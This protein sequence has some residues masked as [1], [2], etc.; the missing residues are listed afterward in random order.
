MVAAYSRVFILVDALDES[1]VSDGCRQR[2]LSSLLNLQVECGINFFATSWPILRIEKEF[3]GVIMLEI[4][5]SEEDVRRYLEGHM[6]RL[7][8]FIVQ[9]FELQDKI[10]TNIV[11]AVDRMYVDLFKN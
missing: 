8:G 9:S 10:E 6:F 2:F 5:A 3:E 11:K 7:P 4:R 1:Q